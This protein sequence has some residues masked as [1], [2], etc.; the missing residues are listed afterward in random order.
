MITTRERKHLATWAA[1][2]ALCVAWAPGAAADTWNERT[3]LTFSEPVMVPGATLQPGTYEFRLADIGSD[4]HIVQVFTQDGEKLVGSM[5]AVPVKRVEVTEDVVVKFNPTDVGTPPA[6]K[7]WFYPGSRFGHEFVYHEEQARQIADRTKSLVLSI[8]TPGTDV[9]KGTLRT[10][11]PSG[12]RAEWRGDSATLKEWEAWRQ[13]SGASASA[14]TTPAERKQ[15]TAPAVRSDFEAPRVEL[16]DL[17]SNTEQYLG[18]T[19]SVDGEVEEV[20]GPRVF[21]ID[22]RN[23]G[24]LDGEILV[25]MPTHLVALVQDDDLVTVTGMV[26]PFVRAEFEQELEWF[27]IGPELEVDLE[28]KPVLV[29]ERIVGGDSDVAFVIELGDAA[30]PVGTS[31]SAAAAPIDS[32]EAVAGAGED[33]VGRQVDLDR[34]TVKSVAMDGGFFVEAGEDVLFVLPAEADATVQAGG[35]VSIEG[36]VLQLPDRMEDRLQAPGGFNSE[37]YVYARELGA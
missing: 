14:D 28:A 4:R 9:E 36:V 6:M 26:K 13:S 5:I 29:A 33:L 32:V 15:A 25:F 10:Y 24:D 2:A 7:G 22:E 19:V 27:E 11:A 23:W 35:T 17:E 30:S 8:D 31:G 34:V 37:I 20:L 16:D 18:E 3:I 1:V 12:A 21:T